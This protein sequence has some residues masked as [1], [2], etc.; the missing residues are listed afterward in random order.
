MLVKDYVF[1][2][3]TL[4]DIISKEQYNLEI[5]NNEL[6]IVSGNASKG[7][8][9]LGEKFAREHNLSLKLFP[10]DWK[11]MTPPVIIGHNTYGEY[12]KLA[13]TNRNKQM[14]NYIREGNNN[15]VIAFDAEESKT[16]T[17][18]KDMIKISKK[19]GFKVYHIKCTNRE[20]IKIKIY[21]N[22]ESHESTFDLVKRI[23]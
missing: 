13:G 1:V 8:D 17:G 23:Q 5:P 9:W 21:N 18:T 10:A 19:A 15:I 2:K 7:A 20:K 14:S 22:G 4:V 16:K 6:E 3:K 11:N 12:N